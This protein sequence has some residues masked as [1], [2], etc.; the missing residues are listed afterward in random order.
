MKFRED[1]GQVKGDVPVKIK[2]EACVVIMRVA[3]YS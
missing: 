3:G 2:L 1:V